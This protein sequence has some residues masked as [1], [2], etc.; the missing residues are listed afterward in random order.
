MTYKLACT[1]C[2]ELSLVSELAPQGEAQLCKGCI[3]AMRRGVRA[4]KE[5]RTRPLSEVKRELG[6]D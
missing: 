1:F 5:G 6:I 2:G 3:D 4:A